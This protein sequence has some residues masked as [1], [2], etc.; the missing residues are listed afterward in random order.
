MYTNDIPPPSKGTNVRYADNVTQV[1]GYPGKSIKMMTTQSEREINRIKNFEHVW[2]IKTNTPKFTPLHI[3][4]K[5]TIPLTINE[6]PTDFKTRNTL[7]G[8]RINTKGFTV[9]VKDRRNKATAAITK[10]YRLRELLTNT[11]RQNFSP[12]YWITPLPTQ[13]MYSLQTVQNKALLFVTN[14]RY[15]YTLNTLKIHELTGTNQ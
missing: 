14:Q 5:T 11:P 8:L 12:P 9:N 13:S 6:D 10:L 3:V 1:V 4:K 7:L 15:S 2:K